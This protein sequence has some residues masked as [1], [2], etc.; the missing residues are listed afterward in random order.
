MRLRTE[1]NGSFSDIARNLERQLHFAKVMA[2]TRAAKRAL[3]ATQAEMKRVFDRPTPYT[4]NSLRLVPATKYNPEAEIY[5]KDEAF[6]GTPAAKYLKAQMEGGSRKHKRFEK[7]LARVGLLPPGWYAVP[8]DNAELDAYGNMSRGQIVKILSAL[9]ASA[10]PTQ[11]KTANRGRGLRRDEQYFG[12]G[13]DQGLPPGVYI[14]RPRRDGKKADVLPVIHFIKRAKY[15]RRF[16]FHGTVIRAF[17]ASI[18]QELM[19][20]LTY[21]LRTAR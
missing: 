9:R 17:N 18:E 13:P 5:V 6:K 2:T 16:D 11:N 15:A 1:V 14:R 12:V 7:S 8:G 10:D 19:N 20:A 21:A 4:L 3:N